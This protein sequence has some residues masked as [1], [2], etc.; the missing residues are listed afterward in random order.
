[1]FVFYDQVGN[2]QNKTAEPE[3]PPL[4]SSGRTKVYFL[5]VQAVCCWNSW[6]G[7]TVMVFSRMVL[8][9][10]SMDSAPAMVVV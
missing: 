6:I 3:S 1:M 10:W 2:E 4:D 7:F 9:A 8:I 5:A